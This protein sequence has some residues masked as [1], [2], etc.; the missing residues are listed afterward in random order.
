MIR[1]SLTTARAQP[2]LT[3]VSHSAKS[4]STLSVL[5]SAARDPARRRR[6]IT[7]IK[8]QER[9]ILFFMKTSLK[10]EE[11]KRTVSPS[12]QNYDWK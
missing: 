3:V 1:P 9:L 4:L 6:M 10:T 7:A 8:T 11:R 5:S 2:G 12:L